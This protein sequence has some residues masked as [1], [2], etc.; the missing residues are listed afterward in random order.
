MTCVRS[1]LCGERKDCW[2]SDQ[3]QDLT[4]RLQNGQS[5]VSGTKGRSMEPL[6]K[7]GQTKVIIRPLEDRPQKGD[8]LLFL[9]RDGK[10]ILH[11]MIGETQRQ[12]L[13]RGDHEVFVN[14]ANKRRILG[15]VSEIYR[16]GRWF[17]VTDLRYRIYVRVWMALFPIR[18]SWYRLKEKIQG[19][20][21]RKVS[22]K[23]S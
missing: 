19:M 11:R 6:L 21:S 13:L 1:F 17:S 18:R 23:K 5:V 8:I 3:A 7:Q 14:R 10:F 2:M 16:K 4:R 12:Y 20:G 22:D 15:V 9:R